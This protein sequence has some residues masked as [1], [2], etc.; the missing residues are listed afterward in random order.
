MEDVYNKNI[1]RIISIGRY[2][3]ILFQFF[4]IS[5]EGTQVI[6]EYSHREKL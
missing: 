3:L 1:L 2:R 6:L 5:M 4:K